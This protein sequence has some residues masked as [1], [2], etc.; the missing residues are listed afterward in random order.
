MS[1]GVTERWL[2]P[3]PSVSDNCTPASVLPLRVTPLALSC[4]L[5]ASSSD[6]TAMLLLGATLSK[7]KFSAAPRLLTLPARSVARPRTL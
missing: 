1:V 6:T 2:A 7:T 3:V 5:M 4:A